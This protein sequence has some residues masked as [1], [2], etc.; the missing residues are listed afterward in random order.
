MI[1]IGRSLKALNDDEFGDAVLSAAD[2]LDELREMVRHHETR[3]R[4]ADE[5]LQAL[6]DSTHALATTLLDRE[7]SAH[8]ATKREL[9]TARGAIAA[10]YRDASGELTTAL[11]ANER[12]LSDL[13]EAQEKIASQKAA[14]AILIAENEAMRARME[15]AESILQKLTQSIATDLRDDARDYFARYPQKGG[16]R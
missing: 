1:I 3:D 6:A 2:E 11:D 15:A 4:T 14:H 16:A 13:E 8:A 9:D 5:K 7:K 10:A 12:L